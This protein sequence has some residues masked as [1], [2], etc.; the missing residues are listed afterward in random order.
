MTLIVHLI[1]LITMALVESSL[2]LGNKIPDVSLLDVDCQSVA[3]SEFLKR[4]FTLLMIWCNHCPYVKRLES[5]VLDLESKWGNEVAFI[6]I[7]ASDPVAYPEDNIDAMKLKSQ[8]YSFPYLYDEY[9]LVA[10][11]LDCQ[12]TPEFLLFD[13]ENKLCFRGA[14]DDSKFDDS[15]TGVLLDD[16]ITALINN[17]AI[18]KMSPALGCSIKFKE[19]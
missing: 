13:R 12:C 16:A 7:S 19:S 11:L 14:C 6:A 3:L 5:T 4:N 18:S 15:A 8:H 9:G 1:N 10:K 2:N 17:K